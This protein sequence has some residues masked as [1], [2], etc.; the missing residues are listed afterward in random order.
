MNRHAAA[1]LTLPCPRMRRL[2]AATAPTLAIGSLTACGGSA[3]TAAQPASAEH[4][5][6]ATAQA[7]L[8]IARQF[9]NEY[10]ANDDGAVYDR[11]NTRSRR[12]ITV[13][14]YIRRHHECPTAPGQAIVRN[15]VPAGQWWLVHYS[16]AGTNLTTTGTTNTAAGRSTYCAA[17]PRQSG[18]TDSPP[19]STSQSSDARHTRKQATPKDRSSVALPE[20][21][22]TWMPLSSLFERDRQSSA[23]S[24]ASLAAQTATQPVEHHHDPIRD[25]VA[26]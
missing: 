12:I 16:I 18:S 9:N 7:L 26:R 24:D 19:P 1:S 14:E 10:A 3:P 15:A 11:W 22:D 23:V 4:A 13:A 21:V 25:L 6:P 8:R 17:T 5:D 2:L 20:R